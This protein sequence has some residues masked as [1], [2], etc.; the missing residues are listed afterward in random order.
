M[1]LDPDLADSG[2]GVGW[3]VYVGEDLGGGTVN[4]LGLYEISGRL[5]VFRTDW[6]SL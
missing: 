4:P 1:Y 5:E 3:R 2:D 6:T